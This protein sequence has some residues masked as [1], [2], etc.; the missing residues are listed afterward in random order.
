MPLVVR[1]KWKSGTREIKGFRSQ[2]IQFK[3]L[4]KAPKYTNE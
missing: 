2:E 4:P 1:M 3:R